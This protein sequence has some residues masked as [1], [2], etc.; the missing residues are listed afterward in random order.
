MGLFKKGENIFGFSERL[1]RA[2][3]PSGFSER[4]F[5][6]VFPKKEK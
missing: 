5:R 4:L 3:F 1:F 2:A 6:A